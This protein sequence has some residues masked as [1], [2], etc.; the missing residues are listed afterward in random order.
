MPA[1][2]RLDKLLVTAA[3]AVLLG[4]SG[5]SESHPDSTIGGTVTMRLAAPTDPNGTPTG[6]AEFA[7]PDPAAGVQLLRGGKVVMSTGVMDGRFEFHNVEPGPYRVYATLLN[8]PSDTSAEFD[9]VPGR[10]EVPGTITLADSG[11]TVANNPVGPAGWALLLMSLAKTRMVDLRVYNV[12][13]S[14][15][16]TLA[17][18]QFP[19]GVHAMAW[20]CTDD[21]RARLAPG[22]YTVILLKDSVAASPRFGQRPVG[23][24][25]IVPAPNPSEPL[26]W[27]RVHI[28]VE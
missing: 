5:C 24:Y 3:S 15:V 4:L 14:L 1:V 28:T 23:R 19:A 12:G 20:D 7:V 25:L 8:T 2:G 6:P 22:R 9:A 16:R 27:G 11:L 18:R 17:S 21:Q 13:G 26:T 10:F